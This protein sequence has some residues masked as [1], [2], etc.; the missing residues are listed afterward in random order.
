MEEAMLTIR[1]MEMDDQDAYM[2][3]KELTL[4]SDYRSS[5]ES[6]HQSVEQG[7]MDA[8]EECRAVQVWS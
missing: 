8:G 6:L 4:P 5:G 1:F 7:G 3:E 2:L